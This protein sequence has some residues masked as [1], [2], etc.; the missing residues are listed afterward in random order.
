MKELSG[1]FK[2]IENRTFSVNNCFLCGCELTEENQTQE[3]VIPRWLQHKFNLWDQKIRLLNGTLIAYRYLTIPC[4]FN[5]NNLHLNPFEEEVKSAFDKGFEEFQKLDRRTIFLWLGKIY[6]G[7]MYK[8]MFLYEDR[9]N[10]NNGT[11]TSESYIKSF[12]SHFLFIQGIR[13]VHSFND[14]FPASIY[15][16]KTQKPKDIEK[17][18]DF[19]DSHDTLFISIRMGEIGLISVLQDCETTKSLEEHIAKHK[20]FP[21]H[22]L[23]FRE[24]T[25]KILYKGL[26]FN[27][28]P[29]FLNVQNNNKVETT[30]MSLQ[31]GSSKPIF[32]D[33]DNN[34]YSILLS[35]FMG[36]PLEVCQPE[37]GKVYTW[38]VDENDNPIFIDVNEK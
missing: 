8:E 37:K 19:L 16:F 3:H 12:Y 22:P 29:K 23:Q 38:L 25:A 6:F 1:I 7:I 15:F 5:C 18:W 27:R 21:L 24:L 20:A 30:L 32:D 33:W 31:G 2:E 28:V 36:I 26:L 14:F 34:Q 35:T 17:Q 13:N 4:C 11:I 9:A 10:P